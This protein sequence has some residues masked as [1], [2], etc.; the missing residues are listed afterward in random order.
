VPGDQR[1][2]AETVKKLIKNPQR[3]SALTRAA[4]QKQ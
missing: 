4:A 3:A 1:E 2:V